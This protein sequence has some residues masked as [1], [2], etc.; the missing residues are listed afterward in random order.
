MRD[1]KLI[2][3][4]DDYGF[5]E[6]INH[7]IIDGYRKGIITSC[8]LMP[9][10]PY[11]DDAVSRIKE[12]PDLAVGVHLALTNG[13]P[14]LPVGQIPFL[15]SRHGD[16]Y[17]SPATLLQRLVLFPAAIQQAKAELSHQIAKI[18]DSGII[19]SH[20][21]THK[22]IHLYFPLF[23]IIIQ[24]ALEFK[25]NA[26]RVPYDSVNI[27]YRPARKRFSR[28]FM[29]SLFVVQRKMKKQLQMHSIRY[30][31]YFFGLAF[32][33]FLSEEVMIKVIER[34]PAGVTELMC[35]P[36]YCNEELKKMHTRLKESRQIELEALISPRVQNCIKE[37]KVILVNYTQI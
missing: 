13:K 31:E 1:R 2:V 36:G 12:Q 11:F 15:V 16:F 26:I 32:T 35:H 7:A 19:P 33:G 17:N 20:L 18:F 6:G 37:N 34:L 10:A 22:H 9:S 5:A 28:L 23:K 3:N 25:I 8:S 27:H 24:L 30:N 14:V 21:D 4:A 29:K